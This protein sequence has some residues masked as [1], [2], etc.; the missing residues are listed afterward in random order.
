VSQRS[1]M[2]DTAALAKIVK[3]RKYFVTICNSL[4]V[5]SI[6]LISPLIQWLSTPKPTL[7]LDCTY[8]L[9]LLVIDD[10]LVRDYKRD[11]T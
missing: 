8:N 4:L 11:K 1:V 2:G 9:P 3:S 10:N 6:N 5:I 7:G